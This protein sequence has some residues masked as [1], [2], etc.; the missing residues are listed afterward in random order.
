MASAPAEMEAR[1]DFASAWTGSHL[2]IW[3]GRSTGGMLDDGFVYDSEGDS[4]EQLPAYP[5]TAVFD[6]SGAW[7]DGKFMVWGGQSG[8]G[9]LD[10]GYYFDPTPSWTGGSWTA[11][12]SSGLTARAA[13]TAMASDTQVLIWGGRQ[14][15]STV[16]SDGA[17]WNPSDN[18]WTT[19]GANDLTIGAAYDSMS[20]WTGSEFFIFGGRSSSGVSGNSFFYDPASSTWR[21]DPDSTPDGRHGASV[22]YASGRKELILFGGET[23]V[24]GGGLNDIWTVTDEKGLYLYRKSAP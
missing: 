3:G 4:W 17:L 13:H 6:V 20:A 21:D 8:S 23:S 1:L 12:S 16:Y 2:V 7:V 11:I 19:L 22:V 10:E 18:T 14:G 9:Y 24:G 15:T 5:G